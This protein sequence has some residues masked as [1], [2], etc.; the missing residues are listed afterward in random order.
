MRV[1]L[2][3]VFSVLYNVCFSQTWTLRRVYVSIT[4][5]WW[6]VV[7]FHPVGTDSTTLLPR[8]DFKPGA[9]QNGTDTAA[10]LNIN[11]PAWPIKQGQTNSYF[12]G[13]AL[14]Q[15][16]IQPTAQTFSP[17]PFSSIQDSLTKWYPTD[18]NRIYT[19]GLS[20]GGYQSMVTENASFSGAHWWDYPGFW[21]LSVG[22]NGTPTSAEYGAWVNAGG[23]SLL[24]IGTADT[25]TYNITMRFYRLTNSILA[26]SSLLYLIPGGG[27]GGWQLEYNPST[28]RWNGM[29]GYENLLTYSKKP[30][31][32]V[33]SPV[34]YLP[35]GTT[36]TTLN[37]IISE[38]PTGQNGWYASTL[39]TK[40]S[41]S[42][43][44]TT[45]SNP[46][47]TITGL[48]DGTTTLTLTRANASGGQSAS[49][50]LT[51]I[52]GGG[53]SNSYKLSKIGKVN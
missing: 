16:F 25:T 50:N 46:T 36:S 10:L 13:Q 11:S 2:V 48:T 39:W 23:R 1:I 49:A 52:I 30:Y 45:P 21:G 5:S 53:T 42:G 19:T 33:A 28:K 34:V 35:S 7:T 22:A 51:L 3:L 24:S 32:A 14:R 38:Y 15:S 40:N 41:G 27:H 47:S 37:G 4:A 6:N 18:T 9:G 31:A 17:T 12:L 20:R 26:G 44:I 29:N 8:M 43:T